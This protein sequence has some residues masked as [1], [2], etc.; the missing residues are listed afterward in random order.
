MTVDVDDEGSCRD[1]KIK[2]NVRPVHWDQKMAAIVR[3]PLVEV[4]L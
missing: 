4:R 3:W 2:V 1:V